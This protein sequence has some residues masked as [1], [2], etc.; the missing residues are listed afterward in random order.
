[1][2]R[3]SAPLTD[4]D[5]IKLPGVQLAAWFGITEY[6][7]TKLAGRGDIPRESNPEHPREW[8][9]PLGNAVSA[10]TTYQR[11]DQAEAQR[12]YLV[13]RTRGQLATAQKKELEI[14]IKNGT[15]IEK[16]K[17]IRALEPLAVL[18]RNTIL[19]R[20]DRFERAVTA[21]KGRK[22]KPEVIRKFDLEV[23]AMFADLVKPLKNGQNGQN[24]EAATKTTS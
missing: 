17:V 16:Q 5:G 11:K 3:R 4:L 2:S 18:L 23:L 9:Y 15:L 22:A 21:A 19:S 1:M 14:A 24:G 12:E 20:A 13:A 6:E 10:Y 8:V 7:L